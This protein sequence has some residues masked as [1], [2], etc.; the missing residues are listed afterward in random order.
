MSHLPVV[1]DQHRPG[2]TLQGDIMRKHALQLDKAKANPLFDSWKLATR[3][4]VAKKVVTLEGQIT[5]RDHNTD[6]LNTR[7]AILH[8][9]LH[10]LGQRIFVFTR[11]DGVSGLQEVVLGEHTEL[12]TVGGEQKLASSAACSQHRLRRAS[13]VARCRASTRA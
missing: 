2:S 3:I 12:R 10:Q 9:H 13:Q 4:T 5:V 6:Y 11:G 1:R 7:A 8:N